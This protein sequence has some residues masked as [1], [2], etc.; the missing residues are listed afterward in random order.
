MKEPLVSVICICYN[1]SRWVKDAIK[2]VLDQDYK[3]IE[4]IVI[5][6]CSSDDS[7]NVISK[8]IEVSPDIIFLRNDINLDHNKTFNKAF[9]KS[10]GAYVID[11][12]ADDILLPG[13][14]TQGV[15]AFTDGP[16]KM[17][18]HHSEATLI[19]EDGSLIGTDEKV[20]G[21]TGDLYLNL[22]A[23]YFI[24][25][26]TLMF[27]RTMLEKL[28]GYN[29]DLVYE[30]FDITIRGSREWTFGFTP[31]V[32][33]GKRIVPRSNSW[34]QKKLFNAFQSSTLRVCE[35]IYVLNRNQDEYVALQKRVLY[36]IKHSIL[37]LN[38]HLIP[39]YLFLWIKSFFRAF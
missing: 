6:D 11:L 30:D 17:G 37:C 13:R 20:K 28:S 10:K 18:F 24:N 23:E 36:E 27:D 19:S 32:L 34:Q 5:D 38:F 15:K 22:I 8:F 16:S 1:Q 9:D 21:L 14:V 26:A 35:E 29:E 4:L 2:S 25:P 7:V 31:K 3:N 12:A 39:S 33:V